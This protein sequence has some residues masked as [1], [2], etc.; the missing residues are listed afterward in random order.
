MVNKN[1]E[2]KYHAPID[3][4]L[5]LL[6][7]HDEWYFHKR[8]RMF[9][10]NIEQF[11]NDYLYPLNQIGHKKG[12]E[13]SP[14]T[15]S[16]IMP[17]KA[18]SAYK[19]MCEN[20]YLAHNHPKSIGGKGINKTISALAE[21][22]MMSCNS[23]FFL[24]IS[25][26]E[27]AVLAIDV[28]ASEN[29]KNRF[30]PS[31]VTGKWSGTMCL[32]ESHCGTD[33]GLI[34]TKAEPKEDHF[35]LNGSKIWI[36]FG[37][38]DL[39]ENIIHLVLAKLPNAPRGS[40]GI[41][42]FA[43]P[44]FLANGKRNSI[45]C[46]GIEEKMGTHLSPTCF[47]QLDNAQGWLIGEKNKGLHAMFTMMNDARLTVANQGIALS[48]IAMQ[49]L[50][51]NLNQRSQS[52]DTNAIKLCNGYIRSMRNLMVYINS[53]EKNSYEIS[54][55][56]PTAKS[57]FTEQGCIIIDQCIKLNGLPIDTCIEQFYVDNRISMLYEGTNGIQAL[58]L[59]MRK[60][61]QDNFANIQKY[62]DKINEITDSAP[63]KMKTLCIENF[64]ALKSSVM[65]LK[66][67]NQHE[68][69]NCAAVAPD[70]LKLF[71]LTIMSALWVKNHAYDPR[72]INDEI[73]L[74]LMDANHQI[75]FAAKKIIHG[76]QYLFNIKD[77]KW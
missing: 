15:K 17:S 64:T 40:K 14:Q 73:D 59:V 69:E 37:E 51:Y 22:M 62:I 33:L 54:V 46:T 26:T 30:L 4:Y 36:T 8:D 71:A 45:F 74:F 21:E 2:F 60:I 16:I 23:A 9:F 44:K 39:T 11:C 20:G 75:K 7:I 31:M 63:S 57:F 12:I 42:L 18:K 13:F 5:K 52:S 29:L 19:R 38:H 66:K 67:W 61:P 34:K 53:L 1:D 47:M 48:E 6:A 76:S 70:F 77:N 25:L 72:E 41:S 24:G 28:F 3:E 56:T 10:E 27:S 32:T 58:D 43:V 68:P 55:L 50:K 49:K 65:Q 35:I